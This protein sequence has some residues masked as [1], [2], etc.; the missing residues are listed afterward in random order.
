MKTV[1]K[2]ARESIPPSCLD[3]L[4]FPS[5]IRLHIIR[6]ASQLKHPEASVV[7]NSNRKNVISVKRCHYGFN[8]Y[9]WQD[10]NSSPSFTTQAHPQMI[11]LTILDF[12]QKQHLYPLASAG[13]L[14]LNIFGTV[15]FR[16]ET[17]FQIDNIYF[18]STGSESHKENYQL[19]REESC[20]WH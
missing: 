16:H 20:F 11:T 18:R 2:R 14:Q 10:V 3:L 13:I 4:V 1:C 15:G 6:S 19:A 8:S 12:K 17:E 5:S 9:E 7:R